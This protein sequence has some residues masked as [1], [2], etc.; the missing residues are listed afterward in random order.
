MVLFDV[1]LRRH[2]QADDAAAESTAIVAIGRALSNLPDAEAR[3]RVLRWAHEHINAPAVIAAQ[4]PVTDGAMVAGDPMLSLEGLHAFFE[5]AASRRQTND[6]P[7]PVADDELLDDLFDEPVLGGRVEIQVVARK[8]ETP[9]PTASDDLRDLFEEP[10][11]QHHAELEAA[12]GELYEQP[13]AYDAL[14]DEPLG[15]LY[16]ESVAQYYAVVEEQVAVPHDEPSAL[17]YEEPVGDLCEEPAEELHTDAQAAACEDQSLDAL[18]ADF[19]TALQSLTLQLHDA[20][21]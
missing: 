7:P 5:P 21:A 12:V 2:K 10:V 11:A 18:V 3:L 6:A 19:A 15:D 20:S 16:D 14:L 4:A 9:A 1:S 13:A 8:E 17:V